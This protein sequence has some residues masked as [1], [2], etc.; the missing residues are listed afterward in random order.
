[1][2]LIDMLDKGGVIVWILVIY[3]FVATSIILARFID[4]LIIH[5]TP[6]QFERQ[7]SEIFLTHQGEVPTLHKHLVNYRGT[8]VTFLQNL[9]DAIRQHSNNILQTASRL[10]SVE[11][12]TIE[13]GFSTLNILASTAPIL[14]LFGTI[15]GMIKAF[16]VIEQ[17]GGQVNASALAGGIWEAMI[18]TG[19]GLAVSVF[20]I[21]NL[22]LLQSIAEKRVQM[23]QR[24][25]SLMI[26]IY[27]E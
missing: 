11:I 24:L 26:E 25:A 20:I 17:A 14:G 16:M 3:S 8:G 15:T 21:L 5:R 18:T 6:L 22:H 10:G 2:S 4:L 1:M 7:L 9:L 27:H 13:R 12:Q 19:V 23:M